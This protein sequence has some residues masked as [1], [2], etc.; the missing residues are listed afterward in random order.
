MEPF[1]P[2]ADTVSISVS[3]ASQSVGLGSPDQIRVMNNGTATVWVKFGASGVTATT[4]A[5]F[6]VGPGVVE[7]LTI[8]RNLVN[9]PVFAAVIAAGATG[10]IY[11]TPGDG[12]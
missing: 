10:S 3:A 9:A 5:G 7:V 6:P 12:I 8:P 11:F 2:T 4:A 1:I